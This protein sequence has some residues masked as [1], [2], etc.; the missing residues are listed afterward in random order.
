MHEEIFRALEEGA[1]VITAGAHLARAMVREFHA[2]QADGGGSVWDRP[3]VLPLDAFLERSWKEWLANWTGTDAGRDTPILLDAFQEQMLWEQIIRASPAGASLLQIPETVRQVMDTWRLVV[4]YRL[5]VDGSY[6]ASDDCAAFAEWSREFRR[7]LKAN[8]WAERAR[9]TDFVR[10]KLEAGQVP[11][12]GMV[13]VAGF[14]EMTPQK[15]DFFEAVGNWRAVENPDFAASIER[16][17]LRD[18]SD[19][20]RSAAGWARG[21]LEADPETTIGVIV[22]PD[23][24]RERAKVER[25]FSEVL[26]SGFH[27]SIGPMVAE[28]PVVHDA[29]LVLE[30]L[31]G[32]MTLP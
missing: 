3:D 14:E 17:K 11:R 4:G 5:P 9:L 19:E 2:R 27:L 12:P 8:G 18:S 6:E 25:I 23:L 1:T 22:T 29:L 20:V 28:Y 7:R 16:R 21:L 26:G 24:S 10:E 31:L 15:E 30:L 32:R 13:F